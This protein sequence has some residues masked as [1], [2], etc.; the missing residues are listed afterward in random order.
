MILKTIND[1]EIEFKKLKLTSN[2]KERI[3]L[4]NK[5]TFET[6]EISKA[7]MELA[8][9][10]EVNTIAIEKLVIK[11]KDNKKGK[12][13]NKLVNNNWL[14]NKF[15]NNL[16]KRANLEGIRVL[17][18]KPEYSSIIGNTMYRSLNKPDM[19]L[20]SIEISRR[21]NLFNHVYLVKDIETQPIIFPDQLEFDKTI[22]N[23]KSLE[24]FKLNYSKITN[25]KSLGSELKNSKM[26]Y[27]VSLLKDRVFQLKSYRSKVLVY[28]FE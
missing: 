19:V 10:Y 27:R 6:I 13:Y 24:E 17:P 9:H 28:N 2:S 14:R 23:L 12:K 11:S 22:D 25:W 26:M 1:K 8:T 5:R 21:A 18:I 3:G 20:A 15:I 4:N 7:I 16:T